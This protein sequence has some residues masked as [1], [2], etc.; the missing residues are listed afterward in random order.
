MAT[1]LNTQGEQSRGGEQGCHWT[2]EKSRSEPGSPG[3]MVLGLIPG[4]TSPE[5]PRG[6]L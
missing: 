3:T 4:V 5:E 6:K 2:V 1:L